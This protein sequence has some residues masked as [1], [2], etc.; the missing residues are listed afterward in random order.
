MNTVQ[1]MVGQEVIPSDI[2]DHFQIC[3][4]KPTEP[5]G[6]RALYTSREII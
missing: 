4:L 3:E 5:Y 6:K 2:W 1:I